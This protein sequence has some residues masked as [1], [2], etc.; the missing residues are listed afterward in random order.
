MMLFCVVP[1]WGIIVARLY[2]SRL[3]A[4]DPAAQS[5]SFSRPEHPMLPALGGMLKTFVHIQADDEIT[6]AM[7]R[8]PG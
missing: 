5:P 7:G 3:V 8:A 2:R 1:A 6:E 4:T